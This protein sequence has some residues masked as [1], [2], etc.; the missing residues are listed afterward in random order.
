MKKYTLIIIIV[1]LFVSSCQ[2][3][4]KNLDA[5]SLKV[6][7]HALKTDSNFIKK[8][9]SKENFVDFNSIKTYSKRSNKNFKFL[10]LDSSEID[11]S[12]YAELFYLLDTNL[13]IMEM[14]YERTRTKEIL[15]KHLL[16]ND[17]SSEC[18]NYLSRPFV[19]SQ[20]AI[21]SYGIN[22]QYTYNNLDNFF[23][24]IKNSDVVSPIEELTFKLFVYRNGE[25]VINRTFKIDDIIY[26][27]DVYNFEIKELKGLHI[28][29]MITSQNVSHSIKL[30]SAKH[31]KDY[32]CEKISEIK[33]E[34]KSNKI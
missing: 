13:H 26:P 27:G 6:L 3:D 31:I 5:F 32:N 28:N 14:A 9:L 8:F 7:K 33:E 18:R 17:A 15:I 11:G 1:T 29:P 16:F 4:N 2:T 19:P 30:I 20:F 23:I 12:K 34:I 22:W 10:K 21:Y 25:E 24:K